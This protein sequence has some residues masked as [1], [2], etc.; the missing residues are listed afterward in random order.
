MK[1]ADIERKKKKKRARFCLSSFSLPSALP[2]FVDATGSPS[3]PALLHSKGL[4]ESLVEQ[5][6]D[7]LNAD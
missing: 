2:V 6:Q 7:K 1:E 3:T 4:L 5:V